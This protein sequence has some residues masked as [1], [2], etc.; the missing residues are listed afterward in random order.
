M[1][2]VSATRH[3]RLALALIAG[4]ATAAAVFAQPPAE[5][6]PT[7]PDPSRVQPEPGRPGQQGGPRAPQG[8]PRNVEGAMKM[9]NRSLR[10]L[11]RQIDDT[12]KKADNLKLIGDAQRGA[13]L[14]KGMEPEKS[15][16]EGHEEF[17][18]KFRLGQIQL[19]TML[20]ELETDVLNDKTSEAKAVLA[21]LAT[22]RDKEHKEFDVKDKGDGKGWE[23]ARGPGEPRREGE[24]R[25]DG[26]K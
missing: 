6:P 5:R 11:N 18:K 12:S 17:L 3:S 10:T 9:I 1:F 13:I 20:L 19:V 22:F 25:E 16:K 15:P 21:K 8:D 7:S 26:K 14:A 2:S 24:P 23:G 4:A